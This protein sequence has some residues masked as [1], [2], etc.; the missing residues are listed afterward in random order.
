MAALEGTLGALSATAL[1]LQQGQEQVQRDVAHLLAVNSA[2]LE[3]II[4][5][6]GGQLQAGQEDSMEPS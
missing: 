5:A 1:R 4:N 6:S 2:V 3:A